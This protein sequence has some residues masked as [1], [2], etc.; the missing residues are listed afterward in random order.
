MENILLQGIK[1]N[2]RTMSEFRSWGK[3]LITLEAKSTGNLM[4]F[5]SHCYQYKNQVLLKTANV[6]GIDRMHMTS[7]TPLP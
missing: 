6:V 4:K 7:Q 1:A 2:C 3:P 5:Y